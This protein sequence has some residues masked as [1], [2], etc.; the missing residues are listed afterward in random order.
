MISHEIRNPLSAMLHCS[1][2]IMVSLS[3]TLEALNT[4]VRTSEAIPLER[5]AVVGP[6][7]LLGTSQDAARTIVYCIQHQ[8]R[9]VDDV[10][11]LSKL[12]SDLLTV[13]PCPVQPVKVVREALQIFDGQLR[14]GDFDFSI[15]ED[16]SLKDLGIDWLAFDPG[17]VL[18][19]LMNMVRFILLRP[20]GSV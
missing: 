1:D 16:Q 4:I 15:E 2:E 6:I 3:N 10:L 9:V 7:S 12:D 17:R 20:L 11:T 13:S 5:H 8:R 19:V 14:S 18:Q